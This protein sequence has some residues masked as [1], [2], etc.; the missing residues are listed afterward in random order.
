LPTGQQQAEIVVP[1]DDP[2]RRVDDEQRQAG[3]LRFDP[4]Q[5]LRLRRPGKIIGIVAAD[6][7][8]L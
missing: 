3:K 7:F 4:F 2:P 5:A 8:Q 6:V 1:P